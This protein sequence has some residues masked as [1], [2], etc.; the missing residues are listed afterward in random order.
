LTLL[1]YSATNRNPLRRW[2]QNCPANPSK[3]MQAESVNFGS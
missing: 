2:P 3:Y 1:R